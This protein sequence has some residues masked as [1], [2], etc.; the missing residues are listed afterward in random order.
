[1]SRRFL[2]KFMVSGDRNT[3]VERLF[4]ILI[5]TGMVYCAIW[6]TLC[7]ASRSQERDSMSCPQILVVVWQCSFYVPTNSITF[8]DRFGNFINTGLVPIIVH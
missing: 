5:E 7:C 3:R 4:S 8:Q 1:K 6:V 2:R